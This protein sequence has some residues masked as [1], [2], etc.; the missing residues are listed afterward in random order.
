MLFSYA[1]RAVYVELCHVHVRP[2]RVVKKGDG[3]DAGKNLGADV[4]DPYRADKRRVGRPIPGR[5]IKPTRRAWRFQDHITT[6]F[7]AAFFAIAVTTF[8]SYFGIQESSGKAM[9]I[10]RSENTNR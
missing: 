9:R 7:T 8:W 10:M 2:H 5:S 6:D 3:I 1:V 4:H